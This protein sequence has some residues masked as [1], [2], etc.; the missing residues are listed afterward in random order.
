MEGRTSMT[1]E[2]ELYGP[3]A[4]YSDHK[5]GDTITYRNEQGEQH[6]GEILYVCAPGVVVQGRAPLPLRYVVAASDDSWPEI[7][8]PNQI[9]AESR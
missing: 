9:S 5:Q 8:Y 6:T 2:E 1:A 4:R 3:A 7:V